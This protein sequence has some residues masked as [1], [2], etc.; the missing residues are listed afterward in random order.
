M[1]LYRPFFNDFLCVSKSKSLSVSA[2]EN[3]DFDP[4]SNPDP[5]RTLLNFSVFGW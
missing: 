1:L 4:D 3:I 5:D 2:F